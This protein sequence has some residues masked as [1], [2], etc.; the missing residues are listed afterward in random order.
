MRHRN[1]AFLHSESSP[2]YHMA[3]ELGLM[4]LGMTH[5]DRKRI[6]LSDGRDVVEFINCSYLGLDL[7]PKVV[8]A[9]H[10]VD[11]QWGVNFCCARSRFSIASLL[12]LEERLSG[13]YA[14]RAV[15]FPSVTATHMSVMP[16]LASGVLI[17]AARPPRVRLLFDRFAHSSMQ[18]FRPILAQEA[19]VE[20]IDHNDLEQLRNRVVLAK[21]NGE[22]PV[23]VA[24][25][26]YSMGGM[27]PIEPMLRMAEELDFY[28]YVDDAH[29]TALWG[30]RGEGPVLSRIE[31]PVP[32]KLILTFSLTKGF[33]ASGGG[34]L[35]SNRERERLIR[36][37]G[38][39]YAFSAPLDFASIQACAAV[40]ELHLDGTVE[41]LQHEL[42]ERV[43]LFDRLRGEVAPFSPIRMVPIGDE[44][45]AI[46]TARSLLDEGLFVSVAFFPIVPRNQAQLRICLAANHSPL[47][48]ATL[49]AALDRLVPSATGNGVNLSEAA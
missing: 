11:P 13:L 42:R 15:T 29:G 44:Q 33:G 2:N 23:Y 43:A 1:T 37:Y 24:D 48:I 28:L 27:C 19:A 26:V 5:R 14:G 41:R 46:R 36:T 3:V 47:E 38:Q 22:M 40:V 35:V 10:S 7:H 21:A 18:Y 45:E 6:T 9:F 12:E 31:G 17:D 49:C 20:T 16:L 32:D 39:V 34:V 25:G 8:E 30:R 4:Q